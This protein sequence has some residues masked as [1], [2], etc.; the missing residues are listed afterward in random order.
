MPLSLALLPSQSLAN[1]ILLVVAGSI[2]VA[3]AAQISIPFKPVPLTLQTLAV[4]MVGLTL[5]ARLDAASLA[6]YL[7]EGAAGLP[8]FANGGAGLAYMAGPTGGF[9]VGFVLMAWFAGLAADLG[10]R[11]VLPVAGF[12]LLAALLLYVPGL[13]WPYALAGLFGVDAGW[14][15]TSLAALWAGWMQPFVIGDALKALLAAV[16]LTGAWDWFAKRK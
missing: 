5:G 8:V 12:A 9:L 1:K 10:L 2:L 4:L 13:A 16:F 15:G 6:L 3:V 11:K 7:A 14:V